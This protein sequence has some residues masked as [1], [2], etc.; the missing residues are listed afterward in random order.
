[1]ITIQKN[2]TTA[3][4]VLHEIY[5]IN[6]HIQQ[7]C[8]MLSQQGFDVFCPN[9]LDRQEPYEYTQ[10][11]VAYVNFVED[12]GFCNAVTKVKQLVEDIRNRYEHIFAVGF[13]VGATVAWICSRDQ[14]FAGVIGYYGSRIR[15]YLDLHPQCP[16]LLFYGQSEKSVDVDQLANAL[17]SKENITIQK[18][19]GEHGF[20]DPYTPKYKETEARKAWTGVLRFIY[21]V[22]GDLME[23][24]I[25][26]RHE[27]LAS[28]TGLT[29]EQ[30]NQKPAKDEWSIKQVMEHLVLFDQVLLRRMQSAIE[31][32]D[33]LLE[34][35]DISPSADRS[36]RLKYPETMKPTDG[37]CSIN[38]LLARLR[39]SHQ[40]LVS[41]YNELP[42]K[43]IL[44]HKGVPHERYGVMSLDQ[45][46]ELAAVHDQRHLQQIQDIRSAIGA[47]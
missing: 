11:Q 23:K 45:W 15:D 6:Q 37:V 36:R 35:K 24:N 28:P 17:Q 5:G 44:Q 39:E 4:I 7:Y 29:E 43:S 9:L 3:I 8:E 19:E 25:V 32:P 34:P 27:L 2:A 18:L 30:F 14:P 16:V 12:V 40:A 46:I 13:S 26:V 1:M 20:A 38:D 41:F 22:R 31:Q 10:D 33:M 21:S 47:K 42:D